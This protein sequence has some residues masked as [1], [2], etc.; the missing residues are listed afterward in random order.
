MRRPEMDFKDRL[1]QASERA[2]VPYSATAIAR[3]LGIRRRQT[4]HRWLCDGAPN[5]EMIAHIAE[6]WKVDPSW[7]A[8]GEVEMIPTPDG[9]SREEREIIG[10]YRSAQPQRR[11]ALYTM[12]KA[13]GK[14]MLVAALDRKSTR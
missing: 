13:L 2:G 11:R 5:R 4:V 9:L 1:K 10:A 7:L 14:A 3:S 12:V 6:C 8:T